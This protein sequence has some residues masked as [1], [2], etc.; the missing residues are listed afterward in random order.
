M[1]IALLSPLDDISAT[2][3]KVMHTLRKFYITLINFYFGYGE[4]GLNVLLFGV[5]HLKYEL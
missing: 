1:L 3:V 5:A 4:R 2:K